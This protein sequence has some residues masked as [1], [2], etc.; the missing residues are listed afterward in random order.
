MNDPHIS[1][2]LRSHLALTVDVKKYNNM[3]DIN[4]QIKKSFVQF[5]NNAQISDKEL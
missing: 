1:D 5:V 2:S 3:R 4:K